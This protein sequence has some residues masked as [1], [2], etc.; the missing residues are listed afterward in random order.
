MQHM[1]KYEKEVKQWAL[2][3]GKEAANRARM[4]AEVREG[5]ARQ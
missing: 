5:V 3:S 4:R 1:S 2:W